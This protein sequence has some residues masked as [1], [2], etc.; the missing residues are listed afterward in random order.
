MASPGF[1]HSISLSV[2]SGGSALCSLQRSRIRSTVSVFEA[3]R[4]VSRPES[5]RHTARV[6]EP[7]VELLQGHYDAWNRGDLQWVLDHCTPDCEFRTAR[8]LPDTESSYRGH[9]G[10][11]R[12]W[13]TWRD[14]WESLQIEVEA[15]RAGRR[16]QGAGPAPLPGAS[17]G[18]AR[19]V[20]RIR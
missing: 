12:F 8:I 16:R 18:R 4:Q 19:G 2:S 1:T 9:E 6:T 17:R 14:P 3:I 5:S 13:R 15:N 7:N 20:N 11:A 10:I